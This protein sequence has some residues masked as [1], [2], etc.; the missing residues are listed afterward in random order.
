MPESICRI[1]PAASKRVVSGPQK[2]TSRAMIDLTFIILTPRR[3]SLSAGGELSNSNGS[4][5]GIPSP[6]LGRVWLDS[7]MT[8]GDS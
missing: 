6:E 8:R 3:Q 2:V 5:R 1:I 7:A 4:F